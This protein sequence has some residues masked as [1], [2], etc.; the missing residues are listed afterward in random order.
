MLHYLIIYYWIYILKISSLDYMFY[1]F[2]I[3]NIHTNIYVN[4]LLFTI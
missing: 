3:L 4:Q 1:I 2:L